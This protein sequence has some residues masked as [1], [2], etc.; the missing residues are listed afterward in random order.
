MEN[1]QE[2]PSSLFDLSIDDSSQQ[3]LEQSAKWARFLAIVFISCLGIGVIFLLIASKE[4]TQNLFWR[5]G[6][7]NLGNLIAVIIL[8]VLLLVS[9]FIT[10]LLRF[11]NFTLK[12]VKETNQEELEKG[13]GS[14]K[15]YFILAG[16]F[17]ILSLLISLFTL[18][19]R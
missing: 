16:L 17:G 2:Q 9:V 15:V 13:I 5:F 10:F 11:A 18:F 19:R 1:Y 3:S 7:F 4:I 8:I 6:L 14:L 12:G